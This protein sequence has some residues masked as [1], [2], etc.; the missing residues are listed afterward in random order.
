MRHRTLSA[1]LLG[2]A[3]ALGGGC[4]TVPD[5]GRSQLILID[6]KTEM[7]MGLTAFEEIKESTPISQDRE[8]RALV[9]RVGRRI[10]AVA[11]LPGARWEFVLFDEPDTLNAFCLPGGKVGVYTGLL[12][13]TRDET[14]LATVIGHEVAHAVARHGAE[15]ISEGMLFELG[16]A[17]L[18][19]AT[20]K[21]DSKTRQQIL[22]A[23]GIGGTLGLMLPHS[24]R[25]ELEADRL[26]LLYMARAGYDPRAAIDFWKRFRA[27]NEK[28]GGETPP[29]FLSTHPL[30][31][32]RIHAL[33]EFLPRAL[34]EYRKVTAAR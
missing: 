3:L 30:D 12:Q 32:T 34:E 23:Y 7:R 13:I 4:A 6:P 15:R 33:Q 17:A 19:V 18:S 5:T 29:E 27:W 28:E 14:G 9:E 22:A 25:Q 20:R 8:A 2:A 24:R 21:E 1:L 16:A 10:A 26:G 31:E 11:P